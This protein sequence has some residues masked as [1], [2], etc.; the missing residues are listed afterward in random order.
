MRITADEIL[1][2][3]YTWFQA[4]A[5]FTTVDIE[6]ADFSQE[7]AAQQ[8]ILLLAHG[9]KPAFLALPVGWPILLARCK[10]YAARSAT[11]CLTLR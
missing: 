1:E 2:G 11:I 8:A 5:W 9:D 4:N 3:L 7:A 6:Q 10:A